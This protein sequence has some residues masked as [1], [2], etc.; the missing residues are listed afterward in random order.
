MDHQN[1]NNLH[2]YIDFVPNIVFV[3]R[4]ENGQTIIAYSEPEFK[5]PLGKI[6]YRPGMILALRNRRIF[7]VKR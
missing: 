5:R 2:N 7:T 4:M 1:K 3:G 6:D